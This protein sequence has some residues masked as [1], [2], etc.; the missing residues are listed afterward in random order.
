MANEPADATARRHCHAAV[1]I[2]N[3][4]RVDG[5]P[6]SGRLHQLAP[7][8]LSITDGH[9]LNTLL[10]CYDVTMPYDS[11]SRLSRV[12]PRNNR[13]EENRCPVASASISHATL[14]KIE[15]TISALARN[16]VAVVWFFADGQV[17]SLSHGSRTT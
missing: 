10:R 2:C 17:I 11:E 5:T 9:A 16:K 6:K 8:V 3:G 7:D 15:R 12:L 1:R 14:K 13:L 4:A